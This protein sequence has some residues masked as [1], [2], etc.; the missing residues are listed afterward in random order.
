MSSVPD[1]VLPTT[2]VPPICQPEPA[3]VTF[4]SE[5]PAPDWLAMVPAL[6]TTVPPAWIARL[7]GPA[8]PTIRSPA[9]VHAAS[10]PDTATEAPGPPVPEMTSTL[11]A[12]AML[13][14]P[15]TES[16]PLP[17][18]MPV[19]AVSA[20]PEP[21]DHWPLL[22]NC[23]TSA[24]PVPVTTPPAARNSAVSIRPGAAV[25]GSAGAV[26]SA[27]LPAVAKPVP[28]APVQTRVAGH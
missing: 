18:V 13:A 28:C 12:L 4:T 20:A 22:P 27:Q 24:V 25:A 14:P 7:P 6:L 17:A 26:R 1:A 16:M 19:S 9:L 10:V 15:P 3:P 8:S 11:P 2:S 23:S 5:P 21:S